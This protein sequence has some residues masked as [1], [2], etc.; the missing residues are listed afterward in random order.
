[1]GAPTPGLPLSV[2]DAVPSPGRPF[3]VPGSGENPTPGAIVSGSFA[4][5]L[6]ASSVVEE[7]T[8]D[9]PGS[10]TQILYVNKAGNDA[11]GA[12]TDEQPFLTIAAAMASITDNSISK[13]YAIYVG[14]GSY[15]DPWGLKP[16]VAVIGAANP[17][18]GAGSNGSTLTEIDAPADTIGFDP[19]WTAASGFGCAFLNY[20]GFV[21]HQT[22]DQGTRP[23]IQPQINVDTCSFVG[24]ADFLGP[25][26][27]GFDNVTLIGCIS[28]GGWTVRGW[29]YLWLRQCTA[30]GGAVLVEAGPAGATANTTLLAQ[31]CSLGSAIAPTSLTARWA[32]PSPAGVAAALVLDNTTQTGSLTLDGVHTSYS[33]VTAASGTL[34]LLNGASQYFGPTLGVHP[35]TVNSGTAPVAAPG[36]AAGAGATAAMDPDSSDTSGSMTLTT[37]AVPGAGAQIVV[38]YDVPYPAGVAEPNVVFSRTDSNTDAQFY[39]SAFTNAGFTLSAS[40]APGGGKTYGFTWLALP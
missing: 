26:D 23:G 1:M 21:H 12:G 35:G 5:A 11:T 2:S 8:E 13:R 28:Y 36:G 31:N 20:L 6:A 25:G 4:S 33:N 27:L 16:W 7:G 38:T 29:Q 15:P 32:A 17:S 3:S 9:L 34:D 40:V 37:G 19:S 30:L 18:N 39:V 24:G 22:W 10:A 14:P